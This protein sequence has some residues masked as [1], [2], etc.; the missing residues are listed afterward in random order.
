M[1]QISRTYIV[2][3][4]ETDSANP[5]TCNPVQ[6]GAVAIHGKKLEVIPGSEFVINIKPDGIDTPEYFT[7]ER[8][9][10]IGWHANLR[11]VSSDD[12][13]NKWKEGVMPE[14]A[15]KQFKAY[16]D[17]FNPKKN[18][19]F[20][21]IPCG[22]NIKEFDLVIAKRLNQQYKISTM[23]WER[24]QVDVQNLAFLW[25]SWLP[26]CPKNFKMDTLRQ[27]FGLSCDNNHD[28]LQ[29]VRDEAYLIS[30]F[31]KLHSSLAP[32]IKFV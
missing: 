22:A 32:K 30:K 1:A 14:Y 26:N 27:H 19:F 28:A 16:V 6:L 7:K 24:D 3:D 18:D 15:W 11:Q 17:K 29:D 23:F 4:F 2:F 10:T 13:V 9:D 12:I 21:P 5:H 8:L 20:A 25:L 31:L